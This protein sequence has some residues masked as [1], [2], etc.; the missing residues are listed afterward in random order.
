MWGEHGIGC[1]VLF[2]DGS[3]RFVTTFINPATW[4]ALS[5]R[6]GGEAVLRRAEGAALHRAVLEALGALRT[7][8]ELVPGADAGP[9]A[10][11]EQMHLRPDRQQ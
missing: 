6:D 7:G 9:L 11:H 8:E 2:G 5:T 3:V 10:L 4:V 1:N